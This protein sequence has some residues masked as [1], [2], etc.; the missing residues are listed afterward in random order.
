[1]RSKSTQRGIDLV[2]VGQLAAI[3]VRAVQKVTA[4]TSLLLGRYDLAGEGAGDCLRERFKTDSQRRLL[5]I[6]IK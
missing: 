3:D 1:M 4:N 6:A 2:N 5:G